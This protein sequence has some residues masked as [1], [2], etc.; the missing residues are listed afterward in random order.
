MTGLLG[1]N[2]PSPGVRDPPSRREEGGGPE[3]KGN[4]GLSCVSP[5]PLCGEIPVS[6]VWDPSV[7]KGEGMTINTPMRTEPWN[8]G[9][10][11]QPGVGISLRFPLPL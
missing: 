11:R 1:G 3:K 8:G 10:L 7:V 9:P 4:S 2:A 5:P 6:V